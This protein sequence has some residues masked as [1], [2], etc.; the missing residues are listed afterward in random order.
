MAESPWTALTI[1]VA[2]AVNVGNL[3]PAMPVRRPMAELVDDLNLSLRAS[4]KRLRVFDF[5]GH[6]GNFLLECGE[7]P[8]EAADVIGRLLRTP[9][10]V[11]AVDRVAACAAAARVLPQPSA[12][13]GLRWTPGVAF[14]VTGPSSPAEPCSSRV[15]HLQQFD[16]LTILAW[17][18]DLEDS[19]GRLDRRRRGGGWGAVSSLVARQLGGVWTARSVTTLK[20]ILMRAEEP[21]VATRAGI[22]S[23]FSGPGGSRCSP[24]GC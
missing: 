6:T 11:I 17:K 2:F 13:T 19:P 4:G 18:R 1:K 20:G 3:G 12:E 16:S 24:S 23:Q 21:P 10:T 8:N 15:A 22:T 7:H 5:F 9:C 14:R